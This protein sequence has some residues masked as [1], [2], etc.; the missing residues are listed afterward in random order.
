MF[1]NT[2]KSKEHVRHISEELYTLK[3]SLPDGVNKVKDLM[4]LAKL[5]VSLFL[6]LQGS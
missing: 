3:S 2:D 5:Q 4:D 6:C 1:K